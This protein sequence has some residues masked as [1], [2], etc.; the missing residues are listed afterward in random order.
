MDFE[1]EIA[2]SVDAFNNRKT[3][4]AL[5][6][7][8]LESIE[9]SELEQAIVDYIYTKVGDDYEKQYEIVTGLSKGF[10]AVYT[11]WWVEA[12]VNNGG[13]NQYFWNSSSQFAMEAI[14]GFKEIGAEKY[15]SLMENAVKIAIDE[16]PEMQKFRNKGTLEAFSESY[17]HTALNELDEKF[18][19]YPE[20]LSKLRITY[21]RNNYGLFTGN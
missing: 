3:Y 18:F 9:D 16:M 20:D 8:T 7:S 21:I 6:K 10:K 19:E 15:A 14:D 2:K 12:E 1:D 13:F 5:D 4:S 11:T 17:E